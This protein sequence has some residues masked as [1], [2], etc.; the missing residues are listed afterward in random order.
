MQDQ[1]D[2]YRGSQTPLSFYLDNDYIYHPSCQVFDLVVV[3]F[4]NTSMEVYTLVSPYGS[5]FHQLWHG[6]I[7]FDACKV[8]WDQNII[9]PFKLCQL[10]SENVSEIC[11]ML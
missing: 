7:D 10:D 9:C 11:Y 3:E 5:R 4:Q 2:M 1:V 6:T 8:R